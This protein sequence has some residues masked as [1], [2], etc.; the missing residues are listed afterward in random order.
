[1]IKIFGTVLQQL[2]LQNAFFSQ[3][4]NQSRHPWFE[5]LQQNSLQLLKNG[6]I[7]N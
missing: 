7:K 3:I 5:A 4:Y 2:K 6:P 1:M